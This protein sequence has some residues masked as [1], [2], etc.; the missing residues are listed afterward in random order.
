MLQFQV[1]RLIQVKVH[2]KFNKIK[3]KTNVKIA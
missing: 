1:N 2:A 3:I